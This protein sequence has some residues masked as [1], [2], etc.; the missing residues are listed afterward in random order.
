MVNF[1]NWFFKY[2]GLQLT[3]IVKLTHLEELAVN[4]CKQANEQFPDTSGEFKRATVL[5]MLMN[6]F[7]NEKE[8]DLAW[9]IENAIRR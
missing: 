3:P 2:F 5:R 9:A 6:V 7:P 4:F 8:R 1:L